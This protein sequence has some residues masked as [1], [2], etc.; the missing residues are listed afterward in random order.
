MIFDK[1]YITACFALFLFVAT[2]APSKICFADK[3]IF[4][5]V[6][7]DIIWS[8][9]QSAQDFI[10]DRTG[11]YQSNGTITSYKQAG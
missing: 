10:F 8:A 1:D 11:L 3:R 6:P 5:R 2:A 7:S 4:C 9:H